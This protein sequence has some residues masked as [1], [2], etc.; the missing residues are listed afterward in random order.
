VSRFGF[1]LYEKGTAASRPFQFVVFQG[2]HSTEYW[3]GLR[4]HNWARVDERVNSAGSAGAGAQSD[5]MTAPVPGK[6]IQVNIRP[7]QSVKSG[8]ILFVLE[9]MKMQFEVKAGKDGK[10]AGVLVTG[11]EQVTAGQQLGEWG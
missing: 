10:V 3:I 2:P 11:G 9:S 7:D 8:E 5:G 1:G 4:G 6:V